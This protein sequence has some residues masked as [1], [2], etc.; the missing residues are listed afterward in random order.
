MFCQKCKCLMFPQDGKLVC[1]K[2]G[3]EHEMQ[4]RAQVI[5]VKSRDREMAVLG[6]ISGTLPTADVECPSCGHGKAY[7]VLRQT[8]GAD[9]PETR[10]FRCVKCTHSWREY[11]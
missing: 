11:A 4:Q 9:E 3:A 6:E 5:T 8:R 10:I 2:C 7:W 1:R